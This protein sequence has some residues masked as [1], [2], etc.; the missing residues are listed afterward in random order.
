MSV[1]EIVD[2]WVIGLWAGASLPADDAHGIYQIAEEQS[3][4]A[5]AESAERLRAAGIEARPATAVGNPAAEILTVA[6]TLGADLIVLG[7]RGRTGLRRLVLGSVARRVL[8][9]A[10]AS[11]LIVRQGPAHPG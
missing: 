2:P 6:E 8:Q 7:T 5:S 3:R 10:T 9:H 11:V 1:A 4:R